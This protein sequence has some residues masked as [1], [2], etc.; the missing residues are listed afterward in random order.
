MTFTIEEI[1]KLIDGTVVG[2]RI[3][4][5]DRVA[6][7]EEATEGS[8]A[9]LS[10]PK[11]ESFIYET[12]ASAVIV[13]NSFEPKRPLRTTLIKVPNA[14]TGFTMLLEQYQ[15]ISALS[16]VGIEEPVYTGKNCS[17]GVGLY[18]GAFSYIDEGCTLG[19]HVKIYP[20]V[21]IGK[22]VQIGS[23]VVI[24]PGAKIYS[25]TI[26]GDHCTLHAGVVLGSDGFGFAPQPDGSYKKIP[27]LG[28]VI[29]E[30]HVDIGANTVIDCATMGSTL[31][32][33]GVKLDNLIQVAH[34]VEVGKNTVIAAQSGISGSTK[35]GKQ[36]IIAGQ[37]GVAGHVQIADRSTILAQTGISKSWE[38]EGQQLFGS[39]A[40]ERKAYI[41][42][43]TIFR[44]LPE[45]L[46]KIEEIEKQLTKTNIS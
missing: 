5:I 27:Q 3:T 6:K 36:C 46:Q 41:R 4:K 8:I 21:Y 13:N 44:K 10:N 37:V 19:D 16:R 34:N 42:S 17:F 28:N 25:G 30:N 35:I 18:R 15:R 31:I 26:I 24:Y 39:P 20:Q 40:M 32:K 11:Y 9:F 2:E 22:N 12:E 23:H 7:I 14:Y 43:Y 38:Q 1:A 45:M 33:E 29:L